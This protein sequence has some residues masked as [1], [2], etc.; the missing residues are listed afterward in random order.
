MLQE[1]RSKALSR[2]MATI[3]QLLAGG[4]VQQEGEAV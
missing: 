1:K 3:E 2:S 4:L